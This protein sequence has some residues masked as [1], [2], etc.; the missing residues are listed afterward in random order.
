[1][2][3]L[4]KHVNI[5]EKQVQKPFLT[6][7]SYVNVARSNKQICV[8]I[9]NISKNTYLAADMSPTERSK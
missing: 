7:F 9:W 2:R 8:F 1:M 4:R 3:F 5:L 6:D